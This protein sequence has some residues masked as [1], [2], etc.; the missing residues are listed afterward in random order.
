M[1]LQDPYHIP[2]VLPVKVQAQAIPFVGGPRASGEGAGSSRC[3]MWES[4]IVYLGL[5]FRLTDRKPDP[6]ECGLRPVYAAAVFHHVPR[7]ELNS[8]LWAWDLPLEY[9]P[10]RVSHTRALQSHEL[11][12]HPRP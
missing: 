10:V 7:G 8:T 3:Q 2:P 11:L 4:H 5:V 1:I 6:V 9:Q 12:Q